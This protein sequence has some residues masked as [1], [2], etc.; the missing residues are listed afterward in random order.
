MEK[1]NL[2]V[3]LGD[4]KKKLQEVAAA[5]KRSASLSG[6]QRQSSYESSRPVGSSAF[7]GSGHVLGSRNSSGVSNATHGSPSIPG[8]SGSYSGATSPSTTSGQDDHHA[9]G[10]GNSTA[11][12]GGG[13]VLGMIERV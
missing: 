11:T 3:D 2:T 12:A 7:P 9:S 6:L 8:G 13:R 4:L 1:V 10:V 5:E